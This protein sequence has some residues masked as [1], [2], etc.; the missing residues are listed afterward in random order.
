VE[1]NNDLSAKDDMTIVVGYSGIMMRDRLLA[2]VGACA[3][4]AQETP[5]R[6]VDK[7]EVALGES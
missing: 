1:T 6:S 3:Y 4:G 2:G 5:A 7:L